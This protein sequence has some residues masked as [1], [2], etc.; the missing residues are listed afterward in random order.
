MNMGRTA[1]CAHGEVNHFRRSWA[2]HEMHRH[3]INDVAFRKYMPHS[4]RDDEDYIEAL[5]TVRA[6]L[7]EGRDGSHGLL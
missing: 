5:E 2:D 6:T 7:T 3:H 1:I 4:G